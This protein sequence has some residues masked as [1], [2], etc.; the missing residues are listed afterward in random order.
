M[1][2]FDFLLGTP[3]QTT[4]ESNVE[5]VRNTLL[6]R[7]MQ[8]LDRGP[9]SLPTYFAPTPQS[10]YSGANNMLAALGLEEVNPS[11]SLPTVDVGGLQAYNTQSIAEQ[12]M[13][14]YKTQYPEEYAR[15]MRELNPPA[16]APVV[17]ASSGGND[18][19][20]NNNDDDPI[21]AYESAGASGSLNDSLRN[22]FGNV[23][24]IG[25]ALGG[26]ITY[27]NPSSSGGWGSLVTGGPSSSS[28]DVFAAAKAGSKKS[29]NP[30][31]S[32]FG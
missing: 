5:S 24:V 27:E 4:L 10:R 26:P 28:Q 9:I 21:V 31:S 16:P 12:M 1:S 23:P 19:Y 11:L 13:E 30:F 18:N 29:S 17:A 8:N 7:I 22:S 2:I 14:A 6:D 3:A 32:L 15:R 20:S 25:A